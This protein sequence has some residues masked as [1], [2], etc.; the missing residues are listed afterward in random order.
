[1]KFV[2][3]QSTTEDELLEAARLVNRHAPTTPFVLQPRTV[4]SNPVLDGKALMEL[5]VIASAEHRHVRIIPQIH[6]WLGV[7]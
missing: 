5:Q 3:D 7:D 4:A 1:V 6:P 2:I